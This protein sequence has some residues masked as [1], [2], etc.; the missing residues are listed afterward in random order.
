MSVIS[1]VQKESCTMK[2][3]NGTS[4][5]VIRTVNVGLGALAPDGWN[6]DKAMACCAAVGNILQKAIVYIDQTEVNRLTTE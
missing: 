6:D 3:N 1:T 4:Q 2:L 5:G